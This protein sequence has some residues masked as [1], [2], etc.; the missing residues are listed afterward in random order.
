M[1]NL[2]LDFLTG[3]ELSGSAVLAKK[4]FIVSPSSRR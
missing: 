2:I 1:V 4:D 3:F